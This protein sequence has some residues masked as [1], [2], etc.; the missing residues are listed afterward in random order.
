[1]IRKMKSTVINRVIDIWLS[2]NLEAHPF[3]DPNDLLLNNFLSTVVIERLL[4]VNG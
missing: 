4:L 2:T 1:M 3:I